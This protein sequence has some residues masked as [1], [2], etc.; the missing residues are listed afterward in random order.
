LYIQANVT[1]YV[2]VWL[3]VYVILVIS[4][5]TGECNDIAVCV[6]GVSLI[7]SQNGKR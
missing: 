7:C 6:G 1:I 5:Y 4:I 2:C 3:C